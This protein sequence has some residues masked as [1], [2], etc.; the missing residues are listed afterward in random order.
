MNRLSTE[1]LVEPITKDLEIENK[2]PFVLYKNAKSKLTQ[3]SRY[4]NNMTLQ[5]CYFLF[6]QMKSRV[7]GFTKN[8]SV[9]GYLKC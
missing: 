5:F 3:F 7:R 9:Q 2:A 1:N 4:A 8:Q 6:S